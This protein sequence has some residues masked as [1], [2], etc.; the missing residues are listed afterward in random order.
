MTTEQNFA[1]SYKPKR[2]KKAIDDC[3]LAGGIRVL[4]PCGIYLTGSIRIR[5]NV[6][7]YPEAGAILQGS[8]DPMDCFGWT[9]DTVEP[10]TMEEVVDDDPKKGRENL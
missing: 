3:F 7:L 1:T 5:S 10:V 6:E 8:R 4:I 2:S 9:K